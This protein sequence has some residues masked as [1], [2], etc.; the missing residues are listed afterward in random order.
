ME[1][2]S[3][4]TKLM[5]AWLPGEQ[6]EEGIKI[7]E[8]LAMK[9]WPEKGLLQEGRVKE[10]WKAKNYQFFILECYPCIYF[11]GVMCFERNESLFRV[12]EAVEKEINNRLINKAPCLGLALRTVV[13]QKKEYMAFLFNISNKRESVF[14]TRKENKDTEKELEKVIEEFEK[15]KEKILKD[16]K[17][18]K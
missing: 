2:N 6:S 14:C 13:L 10:S 9:G 1:K 17:G 15:A 7:D 3:R 4:L 5:P 18:D 11:M 8:R 16:R 12:A